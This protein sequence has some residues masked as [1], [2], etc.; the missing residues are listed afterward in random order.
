MSIIASIT[1]RF[2]CNPMLRDKLAVQLDAVMDDRNA[3][4]YGRFDID[5]KYQVGLGVRFD[6]TTHGDQT[7]VNMRFDA[8][9]TLRELIPGLRDALRDYPDN[10]ACIPI[11]FDSPAIGRT[12]V[13]SRFDAYRIV[14]QFIYNRFDAYVKKMLETGVPGRFDTQSNTRSRVTNRFHAIP[15]EWMAKIPGRFDAFDVISA[16]VP[17]HRQAFVQSGWRILLRQHA[18]APQLPPDAVH[19]RPSIS[20]APKVPGDNRDATPV[21]CLGFIE[22]DAVEKSITDID[23]PDGDYEVTLLYSS[24]FW[25]NAIDRVVRNVTIRSGEEPTLGLPPILNLRSEIENGITRILWDSETGFDGVTFGLWFGS[26]R[27][28]HP[29]SFQPPLDRFTLFRSQIPATNGSGLSATERQL[30]SAVVPHDREPDQTLVYTASELEYRVNVTQAL[31]MW[32]VVMATKGNMRGPASEIYLP[33]SSDSP[34]H[35]DDQMAFDVY[36]D[37]KLQQLKNATG[38]SGVE[39]PEWN[40][41]DGF[42]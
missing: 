40:P 11:R 27:T 6:S 13:V 29:D 41:E 35:P 38:Q 25:Q 21:R 8:T 24:L 10:A 12:A 32:C 14:P 20:T 42:W 1:S 26:V 39:N 16:A 34:R 22:Y 15:Q 30:H 18:A 2:D 36:L 4:F 37:E 19:G 5:C 33:W 7:S 3:A 28:L 31:P 23:L 9:P 17:V